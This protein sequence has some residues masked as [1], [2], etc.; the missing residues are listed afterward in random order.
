MYSLTFIGDEGERIW[1]SQDMVPTRSERAA[2]KWESAEEA[3][4]FAKS[5]RE[6]YGEVFVDARVHAVEVPFV[7]DPRFEVGAE[8]VFGRESAV[9]TRID[10]SRHGRCLYSVRIERTGQLATRVYDQ[11]LEERI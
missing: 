5:T 4:R 7:T 11:E 10:A 3:M 9:V 1:L 8:V 6:H 2:R